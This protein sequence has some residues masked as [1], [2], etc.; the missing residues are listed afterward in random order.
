M[1][2]ATDVLPDELK[3]LYTYVHHWPATVTFRNYGFRKSIT[4]KEAR[5]SEHVQSE[6]LYRFLVHAHLLLMEL[7]K[8]PKGYLIILNSMS[9]HTAQL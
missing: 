9:Q 7:Q 4:V 6:P 1:D 5:K 3:L 8:G 2:Q